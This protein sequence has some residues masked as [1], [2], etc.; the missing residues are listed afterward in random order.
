MLHDQHG[1]WSGFRACA[2]SYLV[3]RDTGAL[4]CIW[5][6]QEHAQPAV[7][8]A[9]PVCCPCRR[10]VDDG[11]GGD[12]LSLTGSN[13]GSGKCTMYAR[14]ATLEQVCFGLAGGRQLH[15]CLAAVHERH[16][17]IAPALLLWQL[18]CPACTQDCFTQLRLLY[19][20]LP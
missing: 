4:L 15:S 8:S 20:I 7:L 9:G 17:A 5:P 11:G 3:G 12:S 18:H 19:C 10:L 14:V 6:N 16:A 2:C 1:S 13:G